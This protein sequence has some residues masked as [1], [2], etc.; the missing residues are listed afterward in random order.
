MSHKIKDVEIFA[1]IFKVENPP[2]D[3]SFVLKNTGQ[4]VVRVVTEDGLDGYG[5]TFGEPV[6]DYIEKNLIEEVVGKDP[7]ANEDI[8]N[9]MFRAIRS[10]GRKG[11]ALLAISAID[12]AIWDLRGKILGQP[13]Y[14]LLGG[15]KRDIPAYASVG[16]LSMPNE[17][18]VEKSLEYIADGYKI[19]KIK[20]GYD[21]GENI[22]ADVN[23]IETVRR[24]VGDNIELIVDANGIYDCANAIRF[25]R[26]ADGL[27]ICLFE[28]PV[29][30]DDIAGLRRI[31]DTAL[32][33][34]ASGENEYT[35]YGCRDLLLADA[36]DVL[37][38]DITRVGGFT[39][40]VKVS[41]MTQAWNL[42]IAPH[43]WPQISAHM[44][45]PAPHGLYLE[46]FPTISTRPGGDI[47]MNQPPVVDGC[48][49]LPTSPGLGLDF[50]LDFLINYK[51]N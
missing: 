21:N 18:V 29:H 47:I 34:V 51:V 33:P 4:I 42:K 12:I 17:E 38:F 2:F 15:T 10:S 1:P 37:Q 36:V 39:E 9:D 44:M 48:Y 28:E 16:F 8:W 41:A 43:F 50:D 30:A 46:V 31:R 7:L 11:A 32:V 23:R 35:K 5:M 13:I 24:A 22:K 25:L 20:V 40:M 45:S 26:A 14:K 49:K 6:C 27:D 3:S 19:L